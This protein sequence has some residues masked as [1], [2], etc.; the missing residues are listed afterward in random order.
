MDTVLLRKR[1][2]IETIIDQLNNI[3]QVEPFRHRRPE[4]FFKNIFATLIAYNF[5]DKNLLLKC[6]LEIL[7]NNI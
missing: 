7:S 6:S 4:N 1:T 2:I 3:S 5:N